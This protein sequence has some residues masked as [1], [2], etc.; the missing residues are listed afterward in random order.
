MKKLILASLFVIGFSA[1]AQH[2]QDDD[3][4]PNYCSAVQTNVCAHLGH[5]T[6]LNTTDEAQFV[7]HLLTPSD[8]QVSD[9][10]IELW[11][12]MGGHGHPG[13]PVTVTQFGVNKYKVTEAYFSMSGT[14][15]VRLNFSFNGQKQ[16]IS[17]P[18]TIK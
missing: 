10:K 12:D 16:Q 17:I 15:L 6:A 7:A 11:M 9:L 5:M 14:W 3:H 8:V 13:A 2:A 4:T 18:L 1:Q